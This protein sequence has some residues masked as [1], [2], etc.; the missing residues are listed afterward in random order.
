MLLR[1][2]AQFHVKRALDRV[3]VIGRHRTKAQRPIEPDGTDHSRQGVQNHSLITASDREG[4]CLFR[5]LPSYSC[6]L[7]FLPY[8][9][10][11][12]LT[13]VRIEAAYSNAAAGA[14]RVARDQEAGV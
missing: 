4:D 7:S 3:A 12:H 11:L 14:L 13:S 5:Q 10:T 6:A 1:T 9:Q 2:Q 8:K